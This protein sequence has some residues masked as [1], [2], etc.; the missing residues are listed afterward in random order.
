MD[1][2]YPSFCKKCDIAPIQPAA[3]RR[4]ALFKEHAAVIQPCRG[5]H[6]VCGNTVGDLLLGL[7]KMDMQRDLLLF[8]VLGAPGKPFF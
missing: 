3:V 1:C 7:R 6:S 4:N 2:G 5:S 8:C